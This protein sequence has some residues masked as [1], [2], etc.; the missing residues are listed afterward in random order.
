MPRLRIL[1]QNIGAEAA[2]F[3]LY[4][5]R[6]VNGIRH[7]NPVFPHESKVTV[8][9]GHYYEWSGNFETDEPLHELHYESP[10]WAVGKFRIDTIQWG[11]HFVKNPIVM[12]NP[13][14]MVRAK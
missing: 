1:A 12:H 6:E 11:E 9:P 13:I 2:K 3:V 10:P 8:E 14:G 7:P 4:G 5:Y